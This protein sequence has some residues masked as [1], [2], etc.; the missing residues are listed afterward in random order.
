MTDGLCGICKGDP[1]RRAFVNGELAKHTPHTKIEA[2]SK[3]V[4]LN[5]KRETIR[6]HVNVCIPAALAETPI[7]RAEKAAA[8]ARDWRA[9][10]AVDRA[11]VRQGKKAPPAVIAPAPVPV[12][13]VDMPTTDDFATLVREEA[14]RKLLAGEL[15]VTTQDG[16][17]AQNLLDKREEKKKDREL[18]AQMGLLLARGSEP[19]PMLEATTTIEGDY[20]EISEPA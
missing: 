15:R 2:L 14:R 16:L 10:R 6:R 18:M 12:A 1:D 4:G 8:R 13:L 3:E 19:P 9:A 5:V 17:S 11:V 20:Q 7:T